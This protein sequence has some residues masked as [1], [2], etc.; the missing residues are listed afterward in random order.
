MK[1]NIV[2]IKNQ[3]CEKGQKTID[4]IV[5]F[6]MQKVDKNEATTLTTVIVLSASTYGEEG[7]IQSIETTC[8]SLGLDSDEL[9]LKIYE[10]NSAQDELA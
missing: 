1:P 7:W 5:D 3:L 2:D 4:A 6:L 8:A 10:L 9:F